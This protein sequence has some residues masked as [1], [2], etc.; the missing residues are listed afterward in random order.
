MKGLMW[1]QKDKMFSRWKERF[2]L[3]TREYLQCFK[4]GNNQITE[5]GDFITKVS[6]HMNWS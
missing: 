1:M 4:R 2:F 3:L 6:Y 5:M